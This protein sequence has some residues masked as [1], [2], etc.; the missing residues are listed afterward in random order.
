MKRK[1]PKKDKRSTNQNA[2]DCNIMDVAAKIIK[3]LSY[4]YSKYL[5]PTALATRE[6]LE[7][8]GWEVWCKILRKYRYNP[9]KATL[10]TLLYSAVTKRFNSIM[11]Y[12]SQKGRSKERADF[13]SAIGQAST[14]QSQ[15]KAA[16]M[17]QAIEAFAQVN[18]RFAQLLI[19]GLPKG[20]I[21]EARAESRLRN[22]IRGRSP[23][24]HA[25]LISPKMI[26]NFF[27]D[28]FKPFNV[29]LLHK[30]ANNYLQN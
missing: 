7:Q 3:T 16:M 17:F 30:L 23:V 22:S 15:E 12:E 29:E 5:S 24:D 18:V 6:D 9:D 2:N 10:S 19:D 21:Q 25:I 14:S 1:F 26:R 8:E 27:A 13:D 4:R 11:R 28:N 20:L